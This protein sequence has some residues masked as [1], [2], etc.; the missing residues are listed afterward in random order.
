MATLYGYTA[1]KIYAIGGSVTR[2]ILFRMRDPEYNHFIDYWNA[3]DMG[4]PAHRDLDFIVE[5]ILEDFKVPYG[6]DMEINTFGGIKFK[7]NVTIID[8]WE[9]GKHD[10]C[11]R[12]GLNYTIENVLQLAPLTTQA[13]AVDLMHN[14]IIGEAGLNALKTHTVAIN[15]L[16][17]AEHY[18]KVYQTDIKSLLEKKA[19]E[20]SFTPIF[21]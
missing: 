17:E 20:Y 7:G 5:K 1:G 18:C 11:T 3:W 21:P 6:W 9:L 15:H 19:A 2:E 4:T 16:A 10:P 12:H 13:I 14:R 8:L